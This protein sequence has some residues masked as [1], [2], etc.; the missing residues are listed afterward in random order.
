[1]TGQPINVLYLDHAA[2]PSGA[3][4]ALLRLLEETDRKQVRPF[5]VFA[6]EGPMVEKMRSLQVETLVVPLDGRVRGARKDAFGVRSLLRLTQIGA[7]AS[8]SWKLAKLAK[9]R[10]IQI[11]HTN[12]MKAHIY[13]LLAG[14]FARLPVVWHIRD[15][16]DPSYLPTPA[17]RVIRLIARYFPAYVIGIS[18]SVLEKV[19]LPPQRKSG[20]VYDGLTTQELRERAAKNG[21]EQAARLRIGLV[22]RIGAWKGQHIFLQAAARVLRKGY[23][24]DFILVGAPLFGEEDYLQ[25]L[26]ALAATLGIEDRVEFAGFQSDVASVMRNFDILVHASI[27]PEPFGQVVIEGMAERLPVIGSDGGGVQE[28]IEHGKSGLLFPMGDSEALADAIEL[29]IENPERRNQ[30]AEA[31]YQRVRSHFTVAR[32]ARQVEQIYV[33]VVTAR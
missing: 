23:A 10:Q 3:E 30:L 5:V 14:L 19:A 32:T 25:E 9:S 2:R 7:L 26:H 12:S 27:S 6:E 13:G 8:Y 20:V 15:Y 28:I 31:G 17:V 1:M 18:R 24:A 11:I 22:G 4:F 33:E 21:T 16:I 29:L